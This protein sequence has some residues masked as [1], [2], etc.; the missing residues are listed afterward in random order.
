MHMTN[1]RKTIKADV[2]CLHLLTEN[3]IIFFL[4]QNY[5]LKYWYT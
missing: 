5:C 3:L 1:L 2:H 4:D